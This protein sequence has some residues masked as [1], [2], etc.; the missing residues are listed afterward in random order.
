[1]PKILVTG[2]LGY[3]GAHLRRLLPEALIWD[4][5][6][7]GGIQGEIDDDALFS[8]ALTEVEEVIHLADRRYQDFPPGAL[9]RNLEAHRS[10]FRG[11]QQL[12]RLRRVLFASS[13]SVY[14][15]AAGEITES[16]PVNP[17][18]AYAESKL[19][20]ERLLRE[21]GLP[22]VIL[23]FGTAFGWSPEMRRD[24]LINQMAEACRKG[25]SLELFDLNAQRPYVHCRDFARALTH[26]LTLPPGSLVNVAQTNRSKREL[27]ETF[28]RLGRPLLTEALAQKDARN[29]FVSGEN[30]QALGFT[31]QWDMEKGIEEMLHAAPG[32]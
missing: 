1:M 17:T 16:A 2:G 11:L 20:T 5:K 4:R 7:G 6:P 32:A 18:S 13:C 8:G 12:P 3:V 29:Y 10:F 30:A 24:L 23:R 27:L 31:F 26:G 25:A 9:A 21:S 19:G 14:G 22:W 15:T 28:Q